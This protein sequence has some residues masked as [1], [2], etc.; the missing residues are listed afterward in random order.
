MCTLFKLSKVEGYSEEAHR[1]GFFFWG[2]GGGVL[3]N[4]YGTHHYVEVT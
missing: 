3:M 2:G 4:D 1:R